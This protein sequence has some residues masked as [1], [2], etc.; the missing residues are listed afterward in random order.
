MEQLSLPASIEIKE[1]GDNQ[2]DIIIGPAYPGYGNTLGNSLRRVLLSSLPGAAVTAVKIKGVTHEFTTLPGVKEDMVQVILN[3]KKLRF[4]LHE[5][6]E[7]KVLLKAKGDGKVTGK[8]IALTSD[9]TLSNDDMTIAT[10]TDK[11][12]SIEMELT[13]KEGRGYQPVENL[14]KKS[15]ELGIINIDAIYTP[16]RNVNYRVENVRVGQ[17]TNYDRVIISVTTDGT[18]SPA[19][20]VRY[21]AQTL[22]DHFTVITQIGAE[23]SG[24]TDTASGDTDEAVE[25]RKTDETE[26]K[27]KKKRGRPKKSEEIK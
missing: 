13:I 21:A 20:A 4:K 11:A 8:D 27:P 10:I 7:V 1:T 9:V 5:S 16:I 12:G 23:G 6:D 18:V 3:L 17:M 24:S 19:E 15:S 26:E 14:E 25:S 2:A 22:V